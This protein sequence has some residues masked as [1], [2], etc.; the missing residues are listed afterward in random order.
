MSIPSALVATVLLRDPNRAWSELELKA[1]VQDLMARIE[2]GGA[3]VYVPRSDRDY[4]I[5]VGL[6]MLTLRHLLLDDDGLLHP[7]PAELTVL[8]YYANSIAH[9]TAALQ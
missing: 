9:H 3:H 4:A 6:R 2:A 1:A 5:D 7:N 8:A